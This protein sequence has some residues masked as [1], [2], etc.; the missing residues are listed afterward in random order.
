MLEKIDNLIKTNTYAGIHITFSSGGEVGERW[1]DFIIERNYLPG[2]TGGGDAIRALGDR[3][4]IRNNIIDLTGGGTAGITLD[5]ASTAIPA[6]SNF[7]IYNNT[8]Y[9]GSS[10]FI[11]IIL[12]PG[13]TGMIVK[14]N[15]GYAPNATSPVLISDSSTGTIKSNNSSDSQVKNNSATFTT[16]PPTTPAHYKP[17]CT[18]GYPCA[19]GTSVPVWYDFFGAAEPET[20][21]I[22]AVRH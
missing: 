19:Q 11:G 3:V 6:A 15:L 13:G 16:M 2:T 9:S 14:N 5:P 18:T 12:P 20:R 1:R 22:G 7:S 8:I 10:D 4:T 17:T 21:D